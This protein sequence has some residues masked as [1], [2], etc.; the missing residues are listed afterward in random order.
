MTRIH[1]FGLV[2]LAA[3]LAFAGCNTGPKRIQPTGEVA[4]NLTAEKK[5]TELE[6]SAGNRIK[7]TFP[8]TAA[9][10]AWQISFH[11][12]RYL[13]QMSEIQPGPAP[14]TGPSI[15]FLALARGRTRLRFMLLPATRERTAAPVDHQEVVLSIN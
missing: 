4:A 5:S 11:D 14:D 3:G 8:P 13:K 12:T 6:A 15:S 1:P 10:H 7:I 2:L 9:G